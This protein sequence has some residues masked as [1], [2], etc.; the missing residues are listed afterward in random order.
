VAPLDR[1][2]TKYKNAPT[3]SPVTFTVDRITVG[4]TQLTPPT[5]DDL[6]PAGEYE[7]LSDAQKLSRPSFEMMHGGIKATSTTVKTGPGIS[8]NIEFE[9]KLVDLETE[10]RATATSRQGADYVL[11]QRVQLAHLASSGAALSLLV[12]GG[13]RAFAGELVLENRRETYEIATTDDFTGR[14]DVTAAT[15][16]GAAYQALD[17]Y[18]ETHPAERGRLQVV[19]SGELVD[20]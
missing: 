3:P 12:N 6:F 11:P 13:T 7:H 8:A 19:P 20:V 14:P 1:R 10:G 2:L 5:I 16:K 18:L 15:T 17:I 9:T 4:A